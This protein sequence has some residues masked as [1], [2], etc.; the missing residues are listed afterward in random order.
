MEFDLEVS[1]NFAL[2]VHLNLRNLFQFTLN[3][4]KNQLITKKNIENG[5]FLADSNNFY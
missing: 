2:S 4:I 5:K 3:W 1:M